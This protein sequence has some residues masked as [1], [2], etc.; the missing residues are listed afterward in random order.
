MGVGVEREHDLAYEVLDERERATGRRVVG[1][2]HTPWPERAH[3]RLVLSD[4]RGANPLDQIQFGA[5]H[6]NLRRR[7]GIATHI[8]KDA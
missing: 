5:H 7:A 1:V 3:H 8:Y 4:H 6:V 2:R